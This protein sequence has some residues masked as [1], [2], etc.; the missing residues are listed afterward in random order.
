MNRP[1]PQRKLMAAIRPSEGSTEMKVTPLRAV[2]LPGI[3]LVAL[4]V[5]SPAAVAKGPEQAYRSSAP[6]AVGTS[7]LSVA[8]GQCPCNAGLPQTA[9]VNA[10]AT[11]VCPCNAGLPVPQAAVL[12]S[13]QCPCNVAGGPPG[14]LANMLRTT[15]V[16]GVRAQARQPSRTFDWA[17]ASVGAGVTAGIGLLILAGASL[18]GRRRVRGQ[19][20]AS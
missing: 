11:A 13:P 4:C 15:K 17:D 3:L 5:L 1:L 20:P 18:A 2:R 9:I 7:N 8:G 12:S 6:T 10:P 19:L 14:G 16:S